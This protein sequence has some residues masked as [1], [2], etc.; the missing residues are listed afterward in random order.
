MLKRFVFIILLCASFGVK[1]WSQSVTPQASFSKD[2]IRIGEPVQYHL[3]IRYP[4]QWQVVFPDST[5]NFGSFTYLSRDYFPTKTKNGISRD[6][7][8]YTLTTFEIEDKQSL[9]LPVIYLK[10]GDSIKLKPKELSIHLV[11]TIK[12][13]R[14]NAKLKENT[15]LSPLD[16]LLNYPLMLLIL[17]GLLL[18]GLIV[19]LVFGKRI[20]RAMKISRLKRKHRKFKQAWAQ[21]VRGAEGNQIESL[22]GRWKR[23]MQLL[24]Q[25]PFASMT[26]EEIK[27]DYA[28]E[29][30]ITA[31]NGLDRKIYDPKNPDIPFQDHLWDLA[32]FADQ[33]LQAAI[34]RLKEKK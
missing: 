26:T 17:G 1:G 22:V 33:E 34:A 19:L 32:A 28:D 25:L 9:S 29:K 11:K 14:T 4:S 7:V 12:Q 30:L 18:V 15:A 3:G 16:T 8:I 21:D 24:T 27:A 20:Y 6:S 31:L 10:E 2:S 5:S 23:H 13:E